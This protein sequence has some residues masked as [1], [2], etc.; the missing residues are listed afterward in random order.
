MAWVLAAG[1]PPMVG[2]YGARGGSKA[3]AVGHCPALVAPVA[4]G[5]RGNRWGGKGVARGLGGEAGR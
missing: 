1:F 3:A 4:G 5:R 2:C